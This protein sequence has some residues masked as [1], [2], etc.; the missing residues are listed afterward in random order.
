MGMS[1]FRK[2][3]GGFLD[4][5]DC[6]ITNYQFTDE[7]NGQPFEPGQVKDPKTGKMKEKFHRLNCVV[8]FKA[9][10]ADEDVTINMFAGG[11]DDFE[12]SDDG[13]IL[14]PVEAGWT[15][16]GGTELA[17]FVASLES[18]GHPGAQ[19]D[20]L[21]TIDFLPIIG[22]RVRTVRVV[23]AEKTQ[24][25]GKTK[26]KDGKKEYDRKD[27]V[28]DKVYEGPAVKAKGAT[29]PATKG[30]KAKATPEVDIVGLASAAILELVSKP[31]TKNKLGTVVL[32]KMLKD[33][34][35]D[36]IRT[37][38]FNDDNL[39]SLVADEVIESFDRKT[40]TIVPK[41]AE[42]A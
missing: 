26:S 10:G 27:L 39:D 23:N 31:T 16:G 33:P 35:R 25:F 36:A 37:W 24:Q 20:D 22:W 40:G 12:V 28:V 17:T 4:G 29:K 32:Q 8:S 7:F 21:D 38:L 18:A 9:D 2:A 30:A 41:D 3:T 15:L 1:R 13:H 11:A 14:T 42:A 5:V 34:N 19:G 6:T